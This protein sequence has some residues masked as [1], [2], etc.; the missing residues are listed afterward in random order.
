MKKTKQK[1]E[2]RDWFIVL[3]EQGYFTGLAQGGK[4]QW[5]LNINEAKPLDDEAKFRFLKTM[6]Y[7]EELIYDFI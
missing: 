7:G 4:T 2:Q 1:N 5:S 6:Q 3:G